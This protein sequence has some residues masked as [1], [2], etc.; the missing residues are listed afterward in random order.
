[1]VQPFVHY[2]RTGRDEQRHPSAEARDRVRAEREAQLRTGR[3]APALHV[4]VG[5]VL[6]KNTAGQIEKVLRSAHIALERAGATPASRVRVI[7]N[8]GECEIPEDGL[9]VHPPRGNVGFG[10]AHNIPME[11]AFEAG[12]ELYIAANPDGMF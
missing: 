6:Y 9:V 11:A 12:A 7:D 4:D 1:K 3:Q 10:A 8:S 2:L 5:I